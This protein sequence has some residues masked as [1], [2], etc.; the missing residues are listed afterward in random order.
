MI[1]SSTRRW[2]A[3]PFALVV[4]VALPWAVSPFVSQAAE[5]GSS[6]SAARLVEQMRDAPLTY[7]FDG[8]VE[9]AWRDGKKMKRA[10]VTVR[11]TNGTIEVESAAGHVVDYGATTYVLGKS[12]LDEHRRHAHTR[13]PARRRPRVDA[14]GPQRRGRRRT[15]G[16][17]R[18][19]VPQ[20]HRRGAEAR[21]R[22]PD[23]APPRP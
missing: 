20:F 17:D 15:T 3:L 19:R 13:Q 2:R 22:H 23:R 8:V 6:S 11:G 21:D 7:D 18:R 4:L 5:R 16:H 9:L 1:T 12:G 10:T 14:H